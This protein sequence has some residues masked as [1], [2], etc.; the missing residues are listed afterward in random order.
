MLSWSIKR[1]HCP[2]MVRNIYYNFFLTEFDTSTKGYVGSHCTV[3]DIKIFNYLLNNLNPLTTIVPHHIVTSQLICAI[4]WF[5][6]A[7]EHWSLMG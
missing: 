7:D 4:D 5:L 3:L 6:Y 2:E 1:G